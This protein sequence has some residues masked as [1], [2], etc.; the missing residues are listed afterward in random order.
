M[1]LL[2]FDFLLIVLLATTAWRATSAGDLVG[3][4]MTF[5]AF[6]LIMS[7]TWLR[8]NA[9]DVALAEATVGAG[10]TGALFFATLG[11]LRSKKSDADEECS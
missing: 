7:V 9:P 3:C 2:L 8:F 1:T 5:I 10:L 11:R 4:V 6:G